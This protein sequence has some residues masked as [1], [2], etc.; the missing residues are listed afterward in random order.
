VWAGVGAKS[1]AALALGSHLDSVAGGGW[2][3]GALG[4]IAAS[5]VPRACAAAGVKPA[6]PLTLVDWADEEGARFGRSLFAS[7]A[8]AGTLDLESIRGLRGDDGRG[9][10]EVLA[11]S[12]VQLDR[13]LESGARRERL[14]AYLELA[15]EQGPVLAAES[16]RAAAASGCP[17]V[18]RHRVIFRG[19]ASHAGTTPTDRRHDAGLAAAEMAPRVESTGRQHRGAATTGA[20]ALRP[21]IPTTVG[22]EAELVIDLRH[23][24]ASEL[25]HMLTEA[26]TAAGEIAAARSCSSNSRLVW[27]IEPIP[28]DAE[29]VALARDSCKQAAGS[30]RVISSGALHDA[31]E[32]ARIVPAAM[33]FAPS[34]LGISHVKEE[35]TAE[36]DRKSA[37]SAFGLVATRLV[38]RTHARRRT[39]GRR[40]RSSVAAVRIP[41]P[42]YAIAR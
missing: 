14:A 13:V 25:G 5:G 35:D 20:L 11:E 24:D 38:I 34:I 7:S 41:G 22:G 37:I 33:V 19:Q 8:F 26:H 27:R 9:L 10:P 17:G 36:Q 6:R 40:R 4:V 42:L 28:F 31:A 39:P 18:E 16:I 21:G 3:D 12:G 15:I 30:D 29:L 1:E 32:L 23:T 2:L